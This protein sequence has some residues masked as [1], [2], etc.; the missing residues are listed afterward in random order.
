[1]A[2]CPEASHASIAAQFNHA[3]SAKKTT[4][5]ITV[6]SDAPAALA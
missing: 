2:R 5:P 3:R 1:M 6:N 4:P